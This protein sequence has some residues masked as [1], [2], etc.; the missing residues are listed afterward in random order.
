[1][2]DYGLLLPLFQQYICG[3]GDINFKEKLDYWDYVYG[4]K[5]FSIKRNI[6]RETVIKTNVNFEAV[7]ITFYFNIL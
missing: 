5:M 3:V 2:V 1:M 4:F 7:V 6:L